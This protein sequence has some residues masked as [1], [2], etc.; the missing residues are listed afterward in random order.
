MQVYNEVPFLSISAFL[1]P[2]NLSG[3][4]K[5]YEHHSCKASVPLSVLKFE[6]LSSKENAESSLNTDF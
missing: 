6:A 3:K 1:R 2:K 4:G 5:F